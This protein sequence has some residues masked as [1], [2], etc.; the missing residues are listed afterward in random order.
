L[1]AAGPNVS[2]GEQPASWMK[3]ICSRR[4]LRRTGGL[5]SA[6][7]YVAVP[8]YDSAAGRHHFLS[9]CRLLAAV[10]GMI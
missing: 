6:S 10:I 7:I 1:T 5:G 3:C 4:Y 8:L 2:N 9:D